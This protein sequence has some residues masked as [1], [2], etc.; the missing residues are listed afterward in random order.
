LLNEVVTKGVFLWKV[1]HL[2]MPQYM[3]LC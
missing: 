3:Q 1:H 2:F